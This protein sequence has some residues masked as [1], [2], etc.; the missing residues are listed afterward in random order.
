MYKK[1]DFEKYLS[2]QYES[3]KEYAQYYGGFTLQF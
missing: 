2:N 3:Y 1:Y